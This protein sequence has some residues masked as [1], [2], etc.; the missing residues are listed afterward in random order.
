MGAKS[1]EMILDRVS[2]IKAYEPVLDIGYDVVKRES[3]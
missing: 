1:M 2:E 3:A